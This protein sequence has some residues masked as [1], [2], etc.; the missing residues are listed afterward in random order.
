M[1]LL[2][3]NIIARI[4][5][6]ILTIYIA[7]YLGVI[8]FG[9]YSFAFAFASIFMMV[10]DFGFG[11]LNIR[12]IARDKN[13]ANHY[14]GSTILLKV[15]LTLIT[16]TLIFITTNLLNYPQDV[17]ATVYIFGI[18]IILN[19][20]TALFNSIFRAFEQMEY[21]S[22][23]VLIEKVT[24]FVLGL[25]ALFV[26]CGLIELAFTYLIGSMIGFLFS[27]LMTTKN[28]AR[29]NFKVDL[30]LLRY[31]IKES[32]PLAI[33][34]IFVTIYFRIDTVM[35]SLMVGDATVGWYNAAYNLIFGL[36][37]IPTAFMG[38]VF[39]RISKLFHSSRVSLNEAYQLSFKYLFAIGLPIAVGT[40]ILAHPIIILLYGEIYVPTV[41]ALQ[42]LIWALF[43]F[44]LNYVVG[45]LL[46]ALDKQKLHAF[47][48][49]I[50]TFVNIVLNFLLIPPMSYVGAGIATVLTEGV[51][52][53]LQLYLVAKQGYVLK[54][55][56]IAVR[57]LLA[58]LIMGVLTHVL[59]DINICLSIVTSIFVYFSILFVLKVI[60][61]DEM[62]IV[63]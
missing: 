20:F 26:G 13:R 18:S 19:S 27:G 30:K 32:F 48:I 56:K 49:G 47:S 62:M 21:V 23:A 15:P 17:T 41:I 29:P 25:I 33:T 51:I 44:Y 43:L 31:L 8:G 12:D 1:F 38:A 39:P 45:T 36:M 46:I 34:A 40:T 6:L 7:R 42:I 22:A 57:I 16:I 37:F 2:S 5:Y 63:K 59:N 53:G 58:S 4:L 14:L 50:G 9:K 52:L 55:C 35:L 3:G 10:S 28:F 11:T 60:T 54:F 24:I 61:R